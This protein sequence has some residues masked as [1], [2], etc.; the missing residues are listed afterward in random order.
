LNQEC[1][2]TR[3]VALDQKVKKRHTSALTVMTAR[4]PGIRRHLTATLWNTL[5]QT[6]FGMSSTDGDSTAAFRKQAAL[7]TRYRTI[8]DNVTV[9]IL[10]AQD[11]RLVFV[12]S[13]IATFLGTTVEKLLAGFDPFRFVRPEER[14]KV[15]DHNTKVLAKGLEAPEIIRFHIVTT[16]GDINRVEMS[17]VL[18]DWQGRPATLNFFKDI[19]ERTLAIDRLEE[20]NTIINR[21]PVVV[22]L[23]ENHGDRLVTFVTEN[24]A[25]VFGYTAEEFITGRVTY[26][27]LLHPD[28]RK[29][30]LEEVAAFNR[31]G[32]RE[33]LDHRPYR[34][35]TKC[36]RVRWVEDRTSRRR[37]RSGRVTHHQG[38]VTDITARRMAEEA[39]VESRDT[40][41]SILSAS[42]VGICLVERGCV[43]WANDACL[44]M[45]GFT[46][47]TQLTGR[48]TRYFYAS[49]AEFERVAKSLYAGVDTNRVAEEDA[50]LIRRDGSLFTGHIKMRCHD[51]AN[52]AERAIVTISDITW[53]KQAETERVNREKLQGVIET[54][55][56]VCHEMNQPLQSITGHLELL[57][58]ELSETDSG[59]E[60]IV[61]INRLINRM[62]KITRRLMHITSYETKPYL[63]N[64]I[65]DIEKA[66]R[67]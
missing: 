39:L 18:I 11:D 59:Y 9:G 25:E 49:R 50:L 1:V 55:G 19:T 4:R 44:E 16:N 63:E 30:V 24:V 12:N 15:A 14:L 34:I 23:W 64:R 28:D 67:S 7:A 5:Q 41:K 53:R 21:S 33:E 51:P 22:F 57:L 54:A 66:T 48:A 40:L 37:D 42:P 20:L 8:V 46:S 29:R 2:F 52:P 65:I 43:S 13:T 47:E 58:A 61:R 3:Q 45:F 31:E 38:I 26:T 36:G 10:V 60:K 17:S 62:A 27:G 56:A 6:G 32:G 35:T